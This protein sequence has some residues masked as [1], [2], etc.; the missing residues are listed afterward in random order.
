MRYRFSRARQTL[1]SCTITATTYTRRVSSRFRFRFVNTDLFDDDRWFGVLLRAATDCSDWSPPRGHERRTRVGIHVKWTH[2]RDT[3]IIANNCIITV[4][5]RV[6]RPDRRH[7]SHGV[8]VVVVVGVGV[9]GAPRACVCAYT[10]ADHY[11][12]R[13]MVTHRLRR[14]RAEASPAINV[15]PPPPLPFGRP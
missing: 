4:R 5:F 11:S 12:T 9:V 7:L 13:A 1:I 14:R 15:P 3:I 2:T 6:F 8:Y 10:Y